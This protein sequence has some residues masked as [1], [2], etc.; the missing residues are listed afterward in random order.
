M[1]KTGISKIA[2]QTGFTPIGE[3]IGD[4]IAFIN[5]PEQKLMSFLVPEVGMQGKYIMFSE[6]A[7]EGKELTDVLSEHCTKYMRL[8]RL[9]LQETE[10]NVKNDFGLIAYQNG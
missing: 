6:I 7:S 10:R 9:G 4:V 2:L 1:S 5:E 3:E 8:N